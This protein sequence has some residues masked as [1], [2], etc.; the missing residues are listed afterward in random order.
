MNCRLARGAAASRWPNPGCRL[1]SKRAGIFDARA[2]LRACRAEDRLFEVAPN[3]N[4]QF[5]AKTPLEP[6]GKGERQGRRSG[7]VEDLA[8]RG[9]DLPPTTL[10]R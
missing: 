9:A 6:D 5:E 7:F 4:A 1:R 8:N 10:H 3:V 2:V